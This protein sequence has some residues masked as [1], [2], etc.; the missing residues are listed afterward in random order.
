MIYL[1]CSFFSE[2]SLLKELDAQVELN[3]D[4]S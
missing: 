4:F 2:D 3:T 1:N